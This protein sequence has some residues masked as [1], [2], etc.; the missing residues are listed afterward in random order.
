MAIGKVVAVMK[1]VILRGNSGSGKTATARAL[2]RQLPNSL[3]LS[4]DVIRRQILH[5]PD[6][7]GTPAIALMA[8]LIDWGRAQKF[9]VIILEGILKRSVYT[10]MLEQLKRQWG[11]TLYLAYFDLPFDTTLAR[12]QQKHRPFTAAQLQQWWLGR[13]RLGWETAEFHEEQTLVEQVAEIR[14]W[15]ETM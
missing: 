11:P 15:L 12:N 7:A 3:L 8:A 2:Q 9:S 5:A 4:Q 10:E 6:T 1:L 14:Q 13:D